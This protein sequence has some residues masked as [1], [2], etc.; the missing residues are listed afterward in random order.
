MPSAVD[1]VG[2]RPSRVIIAEDDEATNTLMRLALGVFDCE[3]TQ[4]HSGL[5]LL[6]RVAFEGPFDVIVTDLMMPQLDGARVIA[7]MRTAGVA[8]PVLVVT[9]HPTERAPE[10]EDVQLLRKPFALDAFRQA[11]RAVLPEDD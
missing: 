8:T 9:G 1:R 6:E 4:T 10:F 11:V 2:A 3:V 7:M 5:E